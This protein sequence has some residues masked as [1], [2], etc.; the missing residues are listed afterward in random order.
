MQYQYSFVIE[1]LK[2][3]LTDAKVAIEIIL[4]HKQMTII[5]HCD[6]VSEVPPE[7][8]KEEDERH[9]GQPPICL[10]NRFLHFFHPFHSS[11]RF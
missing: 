6:E 8:E 5:S 2:A 9:K 11:G 10:G 3:S 7:A 1:Q 4:I